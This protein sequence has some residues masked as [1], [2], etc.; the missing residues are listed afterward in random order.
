MKVNDLLQHAWR[1]HKVPVV[2]FKLNSFREPPH[3]RQ[4]LVLPLDSIRGPPSPRSSPGLPGG[5]LILA[6]GSFFP[7]TPSGGLY[8]RY[9]LSLNTLFC[10]YH[11]CKALSTMSTYLVGT[12]RIILKPVEDIIPLSYPRHYCREDRR[13]PITRQ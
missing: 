10:Q 7:W 3:P 2:S 4:G 5:L 12:V 13:L 9:K 8:A 6:R 1:G 11:A